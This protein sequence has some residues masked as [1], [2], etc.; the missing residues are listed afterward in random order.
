MPAAK[1]PAVKKPLEGKKV[2]SVEEVK[3]RKEETGSEM[4]N[5]FVIEPIKNTPGMVRIKREKGGAVPGMLSGMFTS[6]HFAQQAI[7]QH[8]K[9]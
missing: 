4:V 3:A 1:K 7:N 5:P 6:V 9:Y 2:D 8:L